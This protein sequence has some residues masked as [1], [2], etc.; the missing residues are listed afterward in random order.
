MPAAVPAHH[1]DDDGGAVGRASAGAAKRDRLG[2]AT[3]AGYRDCGGAVV[4]AVSDALH[5]AGNLSLPGSIRG[6]GAK[7]AGFGRIAGTGPG[8]GSC[9]GRRS[10]NKTFRGMSVSEPFIRRPV[11]TSLL[12][13]GLFIL[14]I[15][16]Y[17]FLP[18][19]PLPRVDFP[20]ISVSASLPGA[21]PATVASSLAAPL[22][23]RLGQ[24]AGVTE[25]TSASTMGGCNISLQFDLNRKVDGAARDVQAAINAAAADLP[26]NLPGPPT[27]HKI[28]PADAPIMILAMTSDT[29]PMVNVFEYGDNIVGQKLSQVEG[30][31]QAFVSGAEKSAVRV[32]I[33]PAALASTGLSLEQVRTMLGQVNVDSP[34]GSFDGEVASYTVAS[35]DQLKD[36]KEYQS[37]ILT[38]KNG[39]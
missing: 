20:V 30:V 34:K 4:L 5:D 37:L 28:N 11:G 38:Q 6:M 1:D 25:M 16:A 19:A 32:Q 39:V 7:P 36:A 13:I 14:G 23:K 2:D 18:V 31:S 33:N 29:L 17:G 10:G 9:A 35:N 26:I 21:D 27:Y 15:V 8:G 24:I 22:E 12:A 3:S